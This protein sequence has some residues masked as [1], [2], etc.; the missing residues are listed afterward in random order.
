MT[1]RELSELSSLT[2][3]VVHKIESSNSHCARIE[4]AVVLAD[5]LGVSLEWL[6]TGKGDPY[7][8]AKR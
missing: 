5:A 6:C 1:V 8:K 2:A 3:A 4:T 7:P